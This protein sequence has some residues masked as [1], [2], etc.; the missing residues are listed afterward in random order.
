MAVRD[1][2]ILALLVGG[3]ALVA[4]LTAAWMWYASVVVHGG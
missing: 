3:A 1:R 2:V 4:G